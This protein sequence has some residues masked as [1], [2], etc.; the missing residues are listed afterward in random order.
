MI[1]NRKTQTQWCPRVLLAS[2]LATDGE[3]AMRFQIKPNVVIKNKRAIP[4][5]WMPFVLQG[6]GA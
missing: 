3:R 6:G 5:E 4:F 2:L 1:H